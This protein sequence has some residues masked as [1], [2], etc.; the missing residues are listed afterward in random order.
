M[1]LTIKIFIQIVIVQKHFILVLMDMLEECGLKN[2]PQIVGLTASLGVGQTS[3]DM[4][5]CRDV[6]IAFGYFSENVINF[7]AYAQNVLF[8]AI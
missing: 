6:T 2:K 3:W 8:T 7:I 4:N 5:A 1:P